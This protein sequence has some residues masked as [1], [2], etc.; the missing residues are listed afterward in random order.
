MRFNQVTS[1][2]GVDSIR[3]VQKRGGQLKAI[4]YSGDLRLGICQKIYTTQFSGGKILH[5]ENA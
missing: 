3:E 4:G 2:E 1:H 5:T